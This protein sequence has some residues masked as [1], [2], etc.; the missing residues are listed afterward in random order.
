MPNPEVAHLAELAS[1]SLT[2]DEA[3][4]LAKDLEAIVRYVDELNQLDTEGVP[5]TSHVQLKRG[6]LREDAV[7]PGVSHEDALSQAP[8]VSE[9]GFAVPRFVESG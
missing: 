4:A 6:A 9:G 5:P 1:L 2:G 3:A 8:E 7:Q